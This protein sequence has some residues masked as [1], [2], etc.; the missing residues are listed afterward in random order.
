MC[1]NSAW[2]SYKPGVYAWNLFVGLLLWSGESEQCNLRWQ[3]NRPS[4]NVTTC[5]STFYLFEHASCVVRCQIDASNEAAR[6]NLPQS[7]F[8]L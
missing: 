6:I 7:R 8:P 1:S 4:T 5:V 2:V 3:A